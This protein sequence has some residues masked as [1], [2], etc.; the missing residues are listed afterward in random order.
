MITK[1]KTVKGKFI[2]VSGYV[3]IVKENK[4]L[5]L[6][7]HHRTPIGIKCDG[8]YFWVEDEDKFFDLD[9]SSVNEFLSQ[10]S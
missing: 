4:R 5:G 7:N 2:D 3:E 9:K 1:I 10:F 6:R 8:N